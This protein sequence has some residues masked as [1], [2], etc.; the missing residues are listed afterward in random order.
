MSDCLLTQSETFTSTET[1]FAFQFL[2]D[3][4]LKKKLRNVFLHQELRRRQWFTEL[5]FDMSVIR[6]SRYKI[7]WNKRKEKCEENIACQWP[8]ACHLEVKNLS[9][10]HRNPN[11]WD[12][13]SSCF[14]KLQM[15]NTTVSIQNT[16]ADR[17]GEIIIFSFL[18]QSRVVNT[19][20]TQTH[21]SVFFLFSLSKK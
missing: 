6:N 2:I 10:Q 18:F 4:R 3:R 8:R 17:N 11:S 20:R 14:G 16:K 12:S 5:W 1:A 19:K 21:F 15:L 13:S 7:A 9:A